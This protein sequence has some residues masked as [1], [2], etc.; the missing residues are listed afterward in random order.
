MTD[1]VTHGHNENMKN[2]FEFLLLCSVHKERCHNDSNL[3]VEFH[4]NH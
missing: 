1:M 4:R 3:L 2:T